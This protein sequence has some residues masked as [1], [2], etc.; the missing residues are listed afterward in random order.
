MT[1]KRKDNRQARKI[2]RRKLIKGLTADPRGGYKQY[3][4]VR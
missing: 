3:K 4:K 1:A 2:A